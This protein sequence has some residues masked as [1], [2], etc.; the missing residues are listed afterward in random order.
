[1]GPD[2]QSQSP[3]K[4]SCLTKGSAHFRSLSTVPSTSRS[5]SL[6]TP[7]PG[8]GPGHRGSR[9]S[10]WT[11]T[12]TRLNRCPS[13]LVTWGSPVTFPAV[14]LPVGAP[15]G[16]I[17]GA[18]GARDGA[19]DGA[20]VG[21]LVGALV[22]DIDGAAVGPPVGALEGLSVGLGV[23][24]PVG[25]LDGAIDGAAVGAPVGE[26]DGLIVGLGVGPPVSWH[27]L[28]SGPT[29]K[30]VTAGSAQPGRFFPLS[31]NA[32]GQVH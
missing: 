12:R 24:P 3:L 1:M 32:Y 13:T 7:W 18:V 26:L 21:L 23:G 31:V 5:G 25:A 2:C 10:S 6:P 27:T 14:G 8:R 20:A 30:S 9:R 11:P 15:V 17:E 22:G 28:P 4:S 19:T 16:V 29:L